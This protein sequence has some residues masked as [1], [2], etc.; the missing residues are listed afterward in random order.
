V[1]IIFLGTPEFA[2]PTLEKLIAWQA[3]EVVAVV[4]QPDRPSGRGHKVYAPPTKLVAQSKN[5]AVLQPERLSKSPQT[6]EAMH[7]LNPDLLVMVAF[8]QILK[9]P[10]LEMAP[11]GVVNIHG[12]LL[13]KYRGAAPINWAIINGESETGI[14]TMFSDA[15][16]DT[17]KMLLKQA[18]PIGPDT[19]AEELADTLSQ[20][21][22]DLLLKTL[23]RISDGTIAP[24]EQDDSQA[25]Y[26]PMLKKEMGELNFSKPACDLH[27]L[28]R[29]LYSWPGTY[30]S[31]GGNTLKVIR[32]RLA[33]FD[34][35]ASASPGEVIATGEKLLV[36]CGAGDERALELVE[37]QPPGKA[38][39]PAAS[40]ANGARLTRGAKLG[41]R[42]EP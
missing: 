40:W 21:G 18:V 37:V 30:T 23:E 29:G 10:V 24:Q 14:T 19:N 33:D 8:G 41:L 42:V 2:V 38:R 39:M 13:P 20:V 7:A 22:A 35:P 27:N 31:F 36:A 32:T 16:V 25:S 11:L 34:V 17:G 6:V 12:S 1:R 15:G 3:C 5:I 26:A 28:V 4:C 9:K